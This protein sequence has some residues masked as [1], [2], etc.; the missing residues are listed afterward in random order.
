MVIQCAALFVAA[1]SAAVVLYTF[2]PE[3]TRFYP[4]CV[5]Y[6]VTGWQ[7]PGCGGLRAA[8]H[9]LHGHLALAFHYNPLLVGLTPLLLALTGMFLFARWKRQPL[10]H[11]FRHPG[12]IWALV[13]ALV[14]FGIFRNVS[15]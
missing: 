10:R 15:S 9:L 4:K 7:C 5:L 2:P 12:W 14:A 6:T 1:L 8:H 13:A 3:Q 11:P